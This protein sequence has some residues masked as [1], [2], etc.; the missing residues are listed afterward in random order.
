MDA[1]ALTYRTFLAHKKNVT[2]NI[3]LCTLLGFLSLSWT[4][5][6]H[7]AALS[8]Y[9]LGLSLPDPYVFVNYGATL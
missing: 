7:L 2:Y 4:S 1:L 9:A 5:L 3:V 8:V 6:S